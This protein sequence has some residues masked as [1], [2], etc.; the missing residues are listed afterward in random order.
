MKKVSIRIVY[1]H[2][3]FTAR[4]IH[5]KEDDYTS[6][7]RKDNTTINLVLEYLGQ[8]RTDKIVALSIAGYGI[9]YDIRRKELYENISN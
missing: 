2:N 9:I 4:T 6:L 1:P 7:L 8:F 3:V 5:L